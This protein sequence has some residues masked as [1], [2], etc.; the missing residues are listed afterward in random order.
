MYALKNEEHF[1]AC[2]CPAGAAA[3]LPQS[4]VKWLL[5]ECALRR[6]ERCVTQAEQSIVYYSAE[7]A[8]T[9][10]ESTLRQNVKPLS[11]PFYDRNALAI[12]E[13][14]TASKTHTYR[15]DENNECQEIVSPLST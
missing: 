1:L 8:C 9:L 10:N 7:T 12:K 5:A 14:D 6:S 3:D 2:H 4:S 15:E 13:E 11:Y